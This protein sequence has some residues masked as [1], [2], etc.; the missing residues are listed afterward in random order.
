MRTIQITKRTLFQLY[1]QF[2]FIIFL[3]FPHHVV[4]WNSQRVGCP[5]LH[6]RTDAFH[7]KERISF[8]EKKQHR[9][10]YYQS[11]E[12]TFIME[13]M[14]AVAARH[15]SIC[16]WKYECHWSDNSNLRVE[17]T[18]FSLE[19]L[20]WFIEWIHWC[21]F[22]L[23]IMIKQWLKTARSKNY[24]NKNTKEVNWPKDWFVL[25]VLNKNLWLFI[26]LMLT[27]ANWGGK[28]PK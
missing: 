27:I 23:K 19:K 9:I 6:Y 21:H 18:K 11:E 13:S 25:I 8:R 5:L 7:V 22:K 26:F 17:S 4:V 10:E 16:Q 12:D 2:T 20:T 15:Q 3:S 24:F 14:H 1:P 28:N